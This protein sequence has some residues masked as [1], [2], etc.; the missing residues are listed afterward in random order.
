SFREGRQPDEEP[1]LPD[2]GHRT[3]DT[4][5]RP[6]PPRTPIP[7]PS[8][9]SPVPPRLSQVAQSLANQ[10]L[11]ALLIT[12]LPNIRYRIGFT[13]SNGLLLVQ[14]KRATFFTDGRYTEQ[15]RDEVQGAKVVIPKGILVAAAAKLIKPGKLGIE[16]DRLTV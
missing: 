4:G 3:A 16:A 6:P 1:A 15:A 14:G 10:N 7:A 13:G 8:I 12:H 2:G 9:M 11:D 5:P